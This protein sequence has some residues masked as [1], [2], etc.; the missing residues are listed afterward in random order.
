MPILAEIGSS[1]GH[2]H[3]SILFT[4]HSKINHTKMMLTLRYTILAYTFLN[5]TLLNT[6]E[7]NLNYILQNK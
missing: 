6:C 5:F 1:G 7:I 3:S 2:V 4:T